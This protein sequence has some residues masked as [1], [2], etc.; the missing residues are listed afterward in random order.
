MEIW[1]YLVYLVKFPL[2]ITYHDPNPNV[3]IHFET[4]AVRVSY[5]FTSP[6]K[7]EDLCST[8]SEQHVVLW[9]PKLLCTL[10]VTNKRHQSYPAGHRL[11]VR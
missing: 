5:Q 8:T 9:P 4:S 2:M 11:Y 1:S 6:G 7:P 3:P 10:E